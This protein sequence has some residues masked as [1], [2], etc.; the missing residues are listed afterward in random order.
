MSFPYLSLQKYRKTFSL[1][2]LKC[3]FLVNIFLYAVADPS[4]MLKSYRYLAKQRY[5]AWTFSLPKR[6]EVIIIL[7]DAFW[8]ELLKTFNA[9]STYFYY[10]RRCT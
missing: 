6:N 5:S 3:S 8:I 1:E 4:G 9:G 10:L 7:N 2:L